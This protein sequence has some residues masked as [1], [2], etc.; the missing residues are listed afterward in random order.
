MRELKF[1]AWDTKKEVWTFATLGDLICGAC[2]PDGDK[3]L[4]GAK[5]IWEQY[6]GLKDKNGKKIYEGDICRL[7]YY[8]KKEGKKRWHKDYEDV[9]AAE[10]E[11]GYFKFSNTDQYGI[12]SELSFSDYGEWSTADGSY[13]YEA[14]VIGNIHE[15][16][17]LLGGD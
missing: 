14:E 4:S 12:G 11:D 17:E 1:R 7:A 10:F 13:K 3:P 9:E 8:T 6:T 2:E 16:P 15:N 5:Q